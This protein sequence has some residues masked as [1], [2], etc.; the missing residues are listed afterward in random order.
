M[1]GVPVWTAATNGQPAQAAQINQFLG[2]HPCTFIYQGAI[3]I[4]NGVSVATGYE[5]QSAARV[6]TVNTN[7]GAAAQWVAQPFTTGGSL[8]TS[9]RVILVWNSTGTGADTT[10]QIRTDSAGLPSNVVVSSITVTFPAEFQGSSVMVSAA[11]PLAA[12]VL[13]VT[14]KYH[15]VI[16]GTASTTNIAGLDYSAL[17]TNRYLVSPTGTSGWVNGAA[18]NTLVFAVMQGTTGILRHTWEDGGNRWVELG[19]GGSA[20]TNATATV[21]PITDIRDYTVGETTPAGDAHSLRNLNYT[22]GAWTSQ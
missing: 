5:A 12:N 16:S 17:A 21:S 10:I 15:I 19:H 4:T 8:S 6:G 1:S 14:T 18:N 20:F 13:A 7:T 3:N 9:T 11:L 2:T 22:S